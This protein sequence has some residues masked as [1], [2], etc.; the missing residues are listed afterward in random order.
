MRRLWR[1]G[2]SLRG[3]ERLGND[4]STE[5]PAL[6]AG[7]PGTAIEVCV[8]L[9]DIQQRDQALSKLVGRKTGAG[10]G[11]HDRVMLHVDVN[12]NDSAAL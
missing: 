5:D 9:L 11:I 6:A 1:V 7:T 3:L 10:V 2:R 8:D 12:V 4:L